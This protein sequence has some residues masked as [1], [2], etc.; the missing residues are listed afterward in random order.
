MAGLWVPIGMVWLET[1]G[2]KLQNGKYSENG[3]VSCFTA[4]SVLGTMLYIFQIPS[5]L[6]FLILYY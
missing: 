4:R 2:C 5:Q 3:N 6:I 1:Q